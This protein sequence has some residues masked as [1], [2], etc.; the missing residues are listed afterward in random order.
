MEPLFLAIMNM[1]I[2]ASYILSAVLILRMLL[3]RAPKWISYSLWSI[4]LIRLVSPVSFTSAFSLLG[5]LTTPTTAHNS[6]E[7]GR[8]SCWARL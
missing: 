3:K 6:I 4:V 7:I 5:R 1:S 8:A 2:T